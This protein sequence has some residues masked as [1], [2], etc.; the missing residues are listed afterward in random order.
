MATTRVTLIGGKELQNAIKRSPKTVGDETKKFLTRGL[1]KYKK[2]II[3]RPWRV[4]GT[5]GGAPEATGNLRDTHVTKVSRYQATIGPGSPSRKYSEY[6]HEGTP[7]GQMKGRPWLD[8]AKANNEHRIRSLYL[9]M[10]R[11]ITRDLAK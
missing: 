6:V 10:L 9:E 11:N 8:Y 1:S 4:G 2:S 3:S 7:G 5:G